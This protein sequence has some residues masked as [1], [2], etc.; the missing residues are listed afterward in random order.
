M[1]TISCFFVVYVFIIFFL[2]L[3]VYE[4]VRSIV[5]KTI[6]EWVSKRWKCE[7]KFWHWHYQRQHQFATNKK[8]KKILRKRNERMHDVKNGLSRRIPNKKKNHLVP[9]AWLITIRFRV[10]L[11]AYER[12]TKK[13]ETKEGKNLNLFTKWKLCTDA[14][15][16]DLSLWPMYIVH[17]YWFHNIS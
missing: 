17:L 6:R 2:L 4:M 5:F 3:N 14:E 8:R 10:P 13:K 12:E 15:R 7:D 11:L 16:M 1:T 9:N